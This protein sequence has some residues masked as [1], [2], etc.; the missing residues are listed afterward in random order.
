MEFDENI[1][2]EI[3]NCELNYGSENLKEQS[4]KNEIYIVGHAYGKPGV[5]NFFPERLTDYFDENVNNSVSNY[6]AL[7]GDFVRDQQSQ[8][9]K[10]LKNI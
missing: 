2:V 7:T 9:M 8:V 4:S 5:G 10:K 6:I 1:Y 3:E